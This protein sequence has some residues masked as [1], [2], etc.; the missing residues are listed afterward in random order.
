[1][2]KLEQFIE[3]IGVTSALSNQDIN[4]RVI[5]NLGE[6]LQWFSTT[7]GRGTRA[8]DPPPSTITVFQ[9]SGRAAFLCSIMDVFSPKPQVQWEQLTS[10]ATR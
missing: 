5:T 2:D 3:I 4:P 10:D 7:A 8:G 9:I 6:V 1:M